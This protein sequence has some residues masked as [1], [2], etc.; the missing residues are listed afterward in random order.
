MFERNIFYISP[1]LGNCKFSLGYVF[2]E[3]ITSQSNPFIAKVTDTC[4]YFFR[5]SLICKKYIEYCSVRFHLNLNTFSYVKC[6]RLL[7]PRD[8]YLIIARISTFGG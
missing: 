2:H 6:H 5:K 3:R 4:S 7:L 8:E 1:H